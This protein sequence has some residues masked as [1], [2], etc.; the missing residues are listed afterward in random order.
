MQV[1]SEKSFSA[2]DSCFH[3]EQEQIPLLIKSEGKIISFI[4][5]ITLTKS[6]ESNKFK[7][8]EISHQTLKMTFSRIDSKIVIFFGNFIDINQINSDT[9]SEFIF[10]LARTGIKPITIKQY[11]GLL[12]RILSYAVAEN[13]IDSLP[14]FPKTKGKSLPRASLSREQYRKVVVTAKLLSKSKI[15]PEQ[16]SH[17]NKADGIYIKNGPIS[18]EM[19]G[20]IRFMTNTFLRPV[21]IKL[22]QHKHVEIVEGKQCYLRIS[23]PETKSHTGQV[24]SLR[25]AV[26]IYRNLRNKSIEDGYGERNDYVFFPKITN[27]EKAIQIIS[28]FFSRIL[29]KCGLYFASDGQ[30]RSLYS[31]RHTAITFRLIYGQGIDLLTLARNARTS[32]EMIEKFYASN[33]KAEMN[34]E[35]LQSKRTRF[36]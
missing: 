9:V 20:L 16:V 19:A 24:V 33:L 12:K 27:R 36:G 23:L 7:C 22:L 25:A 35:L 30:K 21:D 26:G 11:L 29:K 15:R 32:V 28:Y 1:F 5:L 31:L 6:R 18:S 4:E 34:V 3:L 2:N 14:I 8:G 10:F 17:R 13:F